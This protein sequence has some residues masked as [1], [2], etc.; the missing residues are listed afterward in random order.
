MSIPT[1]TAIVIAKNEADRITACLETLRWCTETI[2]IDNQSTDDTAQRAKAAGARVLPHAGGFAEQRNSGLAKAETDWVLYIDADERVTPALAG[3]I[4]RV[5]SQSTNSAWSVRRANVMYGWPVAHGG[6]QHD[7]V[8]RLFRRQDLRQWAG[9]I[10]EHAEF[11]GDQGVLQEPLWHFTHRSIVDGLRKSAAWTPIEAR[12]LIEAQTAPVTGPTLVRKGVMEVIRRL[13]RDGGFKDGSVGWVEALV[14]GI[15]RMLVYMQ[16]WEQQQQP[17]A[18]ERYQQLEK[19]VA[20]QWR[21]HG[22]V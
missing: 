20:A 10:H 9:E 3:E 5:I 18:T 7:V 19:E 1:I 12:L 11:A 15:N 8:V 2:V 13:F 6:W 4:R 14:Q 16:V 22:K 21:A 17:S